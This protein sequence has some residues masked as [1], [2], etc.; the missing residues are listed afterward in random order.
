M[1]PCSDNH[2]LN[3]TQG[4][5]RWL[6]E[7]C[8]HDS[9]LY[10]I[11]FI[12][13][14]SADQ[15]VLVLD[16]VEDWEKYESRRTEITF[17]GCLCVRSKMNWG[18]VCMSAGEMIYAGTASESGNLIEEARQAWKGSLRSKSLGQFT[19]DLASTD[20]LLELVFESVSWRL[21]GVKTAH[22]APKPFPIEPE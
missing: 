8:W 14:G 16:L 19:L 6:N 18:V 15:V 20:S 21:A 17:N 22:P 12:R 13:A 5:I 9:V 4:A 2:K 10:E 11:R 3:I 1:S 7:Q